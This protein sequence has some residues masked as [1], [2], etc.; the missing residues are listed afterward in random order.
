MMKGTIVLA[1]TV[2]SA[3]GGITDLCGA[4]EKLEIA[5]ALFF[6]DGRE[7]M[8][9]GE[10]GQFYVIVRDPETHEVIDQVLCEPILSN[11]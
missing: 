5:P 3:T 6:T 9:C 8:I 7:Y 4:L 1:G 2:D 11:F 10:T